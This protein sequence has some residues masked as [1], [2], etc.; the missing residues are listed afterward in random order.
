VNGG[1]AAVEVEGLSETT[2]VTDARDASGTRLTQAYR[3]FIFWARPGDRRPGAWLRSVASSIKLP[4][5][6]AFS[7]TDDA[8]DA[9]D[10]A[11]AREKLLD[12]FWSGVSRRLLRVNAVD[13]KAFHLDD[14]FGKLT[15]QQET[16]A[17]ATQQRPE[18]NPPRSERQGPRAIPAA[19]EGKAPAS[20][21][22]GV[23]QAEKAA[24]ARV[25]AAGG[26]PRRTTQVHSGT[27]TTT[28]AKPVSRLAQEAPRQGAV[29]NSGSTTAA[30][31]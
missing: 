18:A 25:P 19:A 20:A 1:D 13:L 8:A 22:H 6:D 16:P 23:P 29:E 14:L 2:S 7:P 15:P 30:S 27:A 11:R 3:S 10:A 12:M 28:A 24:A 17:P 31:E 26:T 4:F 9:G 5:Q 21:I